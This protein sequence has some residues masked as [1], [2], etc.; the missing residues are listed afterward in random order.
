MIVVCPTCGHEYDDEPDPEE[1]MTPDEVKAYRE[2]RIVE[3]R[4][5]IK[6]LQEELNS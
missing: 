5:Q 3:L 4:T 2:R 1:G 6:A